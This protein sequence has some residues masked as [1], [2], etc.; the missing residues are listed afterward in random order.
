MTRKGRKTRPVRQGLK[1]ASVVGDGF[2]EKIYF[3]KLKDYEKPK[4]LSVVPELPTKGKGGWDRVLSKGEAELFDKERD[5]VY[6]VVD[7]DVVRKDRAWDKYRGR[8]ADIRDRISRAKAAGDTVGEFHVLECMPCIERW[9]LLHYEYSTKAFEDGEAC[10]KELRKYVR[11]YEKSQSYLENVGGGVYARLKPA[12]QD[13]F[14]NG[15]RL[16]EAAVAEGG[17]SFPVCTVQEAV[18]GI[19]FFGSADLR[20][21]RVNGRPA[22]LER[23]EFW[24]QWEGEEISEDRILALTE[25]PDAGTSVSVS[26]DEIRVRVTAMDGVTVR[27]WCFG[28]RC[29]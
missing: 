2:T 20:G 16:K 1:T 22:D 18:R 9:F 26:G 25:S 6:C 27:E 12:Q 3:D 11:D 7:L 28:V 29:F 21:L 17:E 4:G 15:D 5:Y 24:K 13:G 8:I 14:R 19:L 23:M 10:E